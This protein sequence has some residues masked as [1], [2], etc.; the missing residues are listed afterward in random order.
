MLTYA[1]E[2]TLFLWSTDVQL[3]KHYEALPTEVRARL[4]DDLGTRFTCFY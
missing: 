1:D 3:R 4:H 2:Y